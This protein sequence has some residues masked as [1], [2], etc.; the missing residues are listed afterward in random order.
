MLPTKSLGL[1]AFVVYAACILALCVLAFTSAASAA[2]VGGR[3]YR[4]F[5]DFC[6]IDTRTRCASAQTIDVFDTKPECERVVADAITEY[7]R[8]VAGAVMAQMQCRF[9][10]FYDA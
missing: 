4:G 6:V 2:S 7:R 5:V 8:T 10:E 9:S 1:L 3:P